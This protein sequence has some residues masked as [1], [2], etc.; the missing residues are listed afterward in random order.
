[1]EVELE[2]CENDEHVLAE[3]HT[4]TDELRGPLEVCKED[5]VEEPY[6]R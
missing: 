6:H 3:V 2:E 1:M 4:E 5:H